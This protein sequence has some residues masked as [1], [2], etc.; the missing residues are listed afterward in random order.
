VILG[1]RRLIRKPATAKKIATWKTFWNDFT[2]ES[3]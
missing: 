3:M 2:K 1:S